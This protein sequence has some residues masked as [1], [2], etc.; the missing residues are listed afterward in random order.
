MRDINEDLKS[1]RSKRALAD[2]LERQMSELEGSMHYRSTSE[3]VQ[4]GE[5]ISIQEKYEMTMERLKE[6]QILII[7]EWCDTR[8]RILDAIGY[9][10]TETQAIFVDKYLNGMSEEELLKKYH[11]AHNTLYCRLRKAKTELQ[12]KYDENTK[13]GT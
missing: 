12:E 9:L 5:R 10:D 6:K 4:G 8:E 1:I 11:I 13:F 7:M 2:A 3:R